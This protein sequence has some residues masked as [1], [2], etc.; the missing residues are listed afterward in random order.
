MKYLS[1]NTNDIAD[2]FLYRKRGFTLI[3]TLVAVTIV[4]LATVGPLTVANSTLVATYNAREQ[5]TASYL[6]Q[7]GIEYVR[8][9]RDNAY[10]DAYSI[11][12]SPVAWND[13]LTGNGA[14]SL[15]AC[16]N[17]Y[18]TL[19]AI[20]TSFGYGSGRAIRTCAIPSSR[21]SCGALYDNNGEY[22]TQQAVGA[23][24]VFTRTIR[25]LNIPDTIDLDGAPYPEKQIESKVTWSTRGKTYSVTI[26][27]HITPWQ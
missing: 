1:N 23:Q 8:A 19:D 20:G 24:T 12:G 13:L 10:L 22:Y 26:Y 27:H 15:T 6:A 3:E 11:G 5:L 14:L 25:I 2:T 16:R 7:E 18:C 21:S 9:I 4:T 17:S